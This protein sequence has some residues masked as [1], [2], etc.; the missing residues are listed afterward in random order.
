[1]LPLTWDRVDFEAGVVRLDVETTKN[2]DGRTFPF[3]VLPAMADLLH[4]QRLYTDAFEA[5][6][7][8]RIPWVFHRAGHRIKDFSHSWRTACKAVGLAGRI[9][10]DFRRHG[11]AQPGPRWHPG[12]VGHA[13]HRPPNAGDFRRYAIASETDLREAVT[14]LAEKS[15]T[16]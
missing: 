1:V 5:T 11:S 6:G 16:K 14:K 2:D 7:G 10:H 12:G 13:A 4:R 3:D 9:P 15:G 8:E